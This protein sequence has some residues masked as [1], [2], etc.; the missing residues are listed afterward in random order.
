MTGG[1][2]C[3]IAAGWQHSLYALQGIYGLSGV[4]GTLSD[5]RSH[6]YA[7]GRDWH[8]AH[9]A[10]IVVGVRDGR[11]LMALAKVKFVVLII[12]T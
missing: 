9:Q 3:S 12:D 5:S 7:S 8:A 6:N 10:K 11:M 4:M 1:C 2:H